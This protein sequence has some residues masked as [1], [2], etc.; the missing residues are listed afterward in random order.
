MLAD[1]LAKIRLSNSGYLPNY[2][3]HL[4]S[5]KE[6]YDAFMDCKTGTGYF[7]DAYPFLNNSALAVP[8][9]QLVLTIQYYLL[10]AQLSTAANAKEDISDWIYSYMLGFVI[11]V[12]SDKKDIH[13]LIY[14]LGVDNVDDDFNWQCSVACLNTSQ[15]WIKRKNLSK[16][17]RIPEKYED[18]MISLLSERSILGE[19]LY[20]VYLDNELN[21]VPGAVDIRP[22]APF[23]E[24]HVVKAIRLQQSAL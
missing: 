19:S 4:I 21:G 18:E 23:G 22:A 16:L 15:E 20:G 5:D 10:L 2:P 24:P 12:Q 14:P 3:Y 6:L 11:G 13:D 17:I 7:F 9:K 1:I 8:Y